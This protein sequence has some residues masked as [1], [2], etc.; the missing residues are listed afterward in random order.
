MQREKHMK[1]NNERLQQLQKHFEESRRKQKQKAMFD[2]F[3]LTLL[4]GSFVL[5]GFCLMGV[6]DVRDE[7]KLLVLHA[8]LGNR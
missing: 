1:P 2:A 3:L 6:A 4:V 7:L 5:S 8:N